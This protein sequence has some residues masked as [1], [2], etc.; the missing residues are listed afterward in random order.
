MESN[1]LRRLEGD[2]RDSGEGLGRYCIGR[3]PADFEPQGKDNE[4]TDELECDEA[5]DE[6]G[7]S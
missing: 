1:K 3:V 2:P 5:D 6:E 7:D 4:A